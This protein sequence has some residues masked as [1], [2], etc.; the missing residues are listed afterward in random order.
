MKKNLLFLVA[1]IV[2]ILVASYFFFIKKEITPILEIEDSNYT[3]LNVDPSL[4]L[5]DGTNF[6]IKL[7]DCTLSSGTAAK[8]YEITTN[9]IPTDH[10]M[11]PWCPDNISDGPEAGGIWLEG[12]RVYDVDGT[13]IKN[14]ANFYKDN[15]WLMYD[16]NGDILTTETKEDCELAARPN[17]GAAYEN[18]C[19]ECLPAHVTD[20]KSRYTI[21]MTPIRLRNPAI[22]RRGP[23]GRGMV[24]QRGIAFNGIVFDAP[25]PTHAILGAYTLAP[26]DDAGGHINPHAGYHYHAATGV[27][28][29]IA[30]QDG[31]APMIGYAMDGHGLYARLD[32]NGKELD[33]LDECRGH[34]DEL[35]GYHYHVDAAGKNNFI[36]CLAGAYAN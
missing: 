31:H 8:C 7:V 2:T 22:Y 1:A 29:K 15:K 19:V 35:R 23:G 5:T 26:F 14:M 17:V 9:S 21:P 33:G 20:V 34:V 12:G 16:K 30:Q 10:K 36:N 11:G 18:F 3:T 6:T 32:A 13:F 28:K 27:S 4:F 25:A 24:S